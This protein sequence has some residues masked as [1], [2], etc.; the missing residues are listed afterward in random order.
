M[1]GPTLISGGCWHKHE[2]VVQV[3]FLLGRLLALGCLDMDDILLIESHT[4]P[5]PG[6]PQPHFYELRDE[7]PKSALHRQVVHTTSIAFCQTRIV[8]SP[9]ATA[10]R[11]ASLRCLARASSVAFVTLLGPLTARK[12]ALH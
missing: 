8:V 4:E 7:T 2:S 5:D 1:K 6:I 11:P 12:R 10:S 9:A 3:A